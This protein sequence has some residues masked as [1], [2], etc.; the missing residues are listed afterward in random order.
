RLAAGDTVTATALALG[1]ETTSAF[2]AVFKREL[3]DTPA[4]Y[5]RDARG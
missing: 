4:R 5:A 3:G 2:I 1:Y